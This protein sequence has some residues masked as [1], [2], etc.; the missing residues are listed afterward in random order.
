MRKCR[1]S[2]PGFILQGYQN[3]HP[4]C[5]SKN[6]CFQY[7]VRFTFPFFVFVQPFCPTSLKKKHVSEWHLEISLNISNS[8]IFII[9]FSS[10]IFSFSS[11][12]SMD[13]FKEKSTGNHWYSNVFSLHGWFTISIPLKPIQSSMVFPDA[14]WHHSLHSAA[15]PPDATAWQRTPRSFEAHRW[16]WPQ[17]VEGNPVGR[18]RP[19]D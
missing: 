7:R 14:Q 4:H 18:A 17:R 9:Q 1:L 13:W 11:H 3:C 16:S 2:Q 19:G 15:P 12:H 6:V 5:R 10:H 8:S